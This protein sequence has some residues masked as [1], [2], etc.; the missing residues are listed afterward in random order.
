MFLCFVNLARG[1]ATGERNRTLQPPQFLV[2]LLK[3]KKSFQ[4]FNFE[5]CSFRPKERLYIQPIKWDESRETSPKFP[6]TQD[7]HCKH[8]YKGQ[9]QGRFSF[10]PSRKKVSDHMFLKIRLLKVVLKSIT[11][12]KLSLRYIGLFMI[13]DKEGKCAYHLML[14]SK[15]GKMHDMFHV[16]LLK[17]HVKDPTHILIEESVK[18]WEDLT[19]V[20]YLVKI[21]DI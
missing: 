19:Y 10:Q 4:L 6:V 20:E 13:L 11:W 17:V 5:H 14:P 3:K 15:Y 1:E 12:G 2:P 21:L 7:T 9:Y 18:I 8:Y 16:S